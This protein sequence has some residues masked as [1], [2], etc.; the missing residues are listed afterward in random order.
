MILSRM[1][2]LVVSTVIMD[3]DL[4][5]CKN[6]CLNRLNNV[7]LDSMAVETPTRQLRM[8]QVNYFEI[9]V[10]LWYS[11]IIQGAAA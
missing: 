3:E 6:F 10:K 2:C 5:N 1:S 9:Y 7:S 8:F 11:V 4:I